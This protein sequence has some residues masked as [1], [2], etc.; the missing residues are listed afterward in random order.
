[1]TADLDAEAPLVLVVDDDDAVRRGL[2]SLLRSVGFRVEPFASGRELLHSNLARDG[3]CLILDVRMPMSSGFD[4]QGELA[5][6]GIKVPIVFITGHGD[7]PMSVRAMKAGAID[8][9]GKP[10]RDQDLLDAVASAVEADRKRRADEGVA[11]NL[12]EL[13]ASLSERE[14]QVMA[15]ATTGLMNKQ[16]AFELGLSEITVKI[17]RGR[18]MRKMRAASFADLVRIADALGLS[19]R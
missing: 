13:F 16:I 3:N 1:M 6:A 5:R 14:K 10:F 8:F 18:A 15:L 4:L 9:L 2:Q 12:A 11:G 17:H 19:R 7:I